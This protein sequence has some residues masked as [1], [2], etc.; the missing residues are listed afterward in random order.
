MCAC[1][2]GITNLPIVYVSIC[3]NL[4]PLTT[5]L[6]SAPVLKEKISWSSIIQA[7]VSFF[8]IVLIVIGSNQAEPNPGLYTNKSSTERIAS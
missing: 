5:V 4:G 8:G 1:V 6:L 3:L 2:T 7:I